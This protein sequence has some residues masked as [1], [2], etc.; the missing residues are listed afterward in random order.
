VIGRRRRH[1]DDSVDVRIVGGVV[2]GVR[3]RG[4]LAWRGIPY[5][6]APVGRLRFASPGDVVPWPGIRDAAGFGAIAPQAIRN[7]LV[8]P[9]IAAITADEDCLTVN[10]HAPIWDDPATTPLPVMVYIHGGGYSA[11]SARDFSGQGEGF[12]RDGRVVYVSFNYRLGALGY[13]DFSRYS[14][15]QR[16][17]ASNPGLRDQ[18]ALLRWVRD[19]ISAFGGDPANVTVFGASAG[20]NAVTT[21]MATPSARGLFARAIAQS[22]PSSAVYPSS[23]AARWA[24]EYVEILGGIVG[25]RERQERDG[26]RDA[27]GIRRSPQELLTTAAPNDLVAACAVLQARTP[28]DYPG[29]FCLA[30]VIDGDLL[31]RNPI[32]AFRDG[33]AHRV[34][35]II[36][37]NDREGAIFR[38]RVDILPRTPTRIEALFTRAPVGAR[39]AMRDAYPG[40]PARRPAADFGG[41]F[42]F[43]FPSTRVAD[44][45]SRHAPAWSYRFDVAPR[46]LEVLGLDATHGVEMFALFDRTDLALARIMTILGGYEEYAAAGVR[47]RAMWLR[48]AADAPPDDGWPRYDER[49]RATLIIAEVDRVEHDPRRDRRRAWSRFLPALAG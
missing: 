46:L 27:G 33:T 36:G 29:A 26:K 44:F 43:W 42:G 4:L 15:P 13:L 16:S 19:N 7:P 22:A 9:P 10:V 20:G 48:F 5:A 49:D 45:H 35:L 25:R 41:D 12:V 40:L 21:L 34:P 1:D 38:G 11:G 28:D 24:G 3:E 23:L 14:T 47:M 8:H 2:R 6:A 39:Q 37:T 32:R 30:P 31:P 18:V 17:F